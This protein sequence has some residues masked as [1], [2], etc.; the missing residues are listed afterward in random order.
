M[1][2]GADDCKNYNRHWKLYADLQTKG[3]LCKS[4]IFRK[5]DFAHKV[6]VSPHKSEIFARVFKR[7]R[8][9]GESYL[10]FCRRARG[11]PAARADRPQ[12][13]ITMIIMAHLITLCARGGG[14][15]GRGGPFIRHLRSSRGGTFRIV[16]V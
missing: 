16:C 5:P 3:F 7:N 13:T 4:P 6:V 11:R 10:H 15:G 12:I 8:T 14:S 9:V 2:P 1:A